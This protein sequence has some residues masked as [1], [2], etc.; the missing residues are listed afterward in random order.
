[1]VWIDLQWGQQYIKLLIPAGHIR[2]ALL[3]FIGNPQQL[4]LLEILQAVNIT[5]FLHTVL[6][7][8]YRFKLHYEAYIE[9][10]P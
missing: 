8:N 4:E 1:M 6:F 10:Y 3:A 9:F 5:A 7:I 2:E